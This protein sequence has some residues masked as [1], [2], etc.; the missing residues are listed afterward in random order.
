MLQLVLLLVLLL[1]LGELVLLQLVLL[2]LVLLLLLVLLLELL[3]QLVLLL[4]LGER[5][6]RPHNLLQ[7]DFSLPPTSF[8]VLAPGRPIL[9]LPPTSSLVLAPGR[10]VLILPP[11]P[12]I[13]LPHPLRQSDPTHPPGIEPVLRQR[14]LAPTCSLVLARGRPIL[15]LPLPPILPLIMPLASLIT[16]ARPTRS[17]SARPRR[18]SARL[19]NSHGSFVGARPANTRS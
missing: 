7:C 11:M 18:K 2:Q 12:P 10:P 9:L 15:I 5:G 14:A 1:E 6:A 4:E 3:L 13:L 8:L 19:W 17:N 16:G